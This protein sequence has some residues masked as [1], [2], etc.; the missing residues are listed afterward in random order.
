MVPMIGMRRPRLARSERGAELI[1]LMLV[2]PILL[3]MFAAIFDFAMMFRSWEVVTNAA[4]EGARVGTLPGYSADDMTVRVQTYMRSGGV[5]DAAA[6]CTLETP[7]AGVCPASDCS[8]CV[9]D[10]TVQVGAAICAAGRSV[11]VVA[12][13]TLPSLSGFATFF[14][15]SFGTI[16]VGS[17]SVMRTE[18]AASAACP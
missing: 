17:T 4:R 7:S 9:V 6:T 14:G 18:A 16:P 15:G 3:L 11:T 1:E 2:T 10:T 12:N 8:V 5:L 13:Q